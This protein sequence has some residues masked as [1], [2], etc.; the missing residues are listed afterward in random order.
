LPELRLERE[1]TEINFQQIG[2]KRLTQTFWLPQQVTVAI[3]WDGKQL[4]NTHAYSDFRLFSVDATERV[5][6]P[7]RQAAENSSTQSTSP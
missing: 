7:K 5:G 2:F 4:R 3:D 6:T 1:S